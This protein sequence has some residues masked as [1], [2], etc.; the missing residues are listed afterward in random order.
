MNTPGVDVRN[1]KAVQGDICSN[2]YSLISKQTL[3]Q[4]E[5]TLW[6]ILNYGRVPNE[7]LNEITIMSILH[8]ISSQNL[9]NSEK[10]VK[11]GERENRIYSAL[12]RNKYIGFGHGIGRSGNLDDVQPKSAGNSV[13]AKATTSFVKDL[14]KSFGIKGCED[15]YILPYATGMCLSTCILYTKKEREKSEY[16]IVSRIDH[17][18]CYKCIDFCALKYLVVDMV[19]R[20]EELHTNLSEIEKL[21]QTY[22]EKICCVMSVTSSYAPRNSDDIV[23]IGHMCRRYNIPHIINNAFGLQCNY[24]C[25]EIQKCFE[26]KGRVD[27]VVQSCDK[28]F[29]VPVNGGIVF[30]SDKKKMK[31]LKKHYPGRTPVHAYLDLFITLL[32]LGK[33]KI[34]NLRKEREENFAW[35]KDKVSTLCSKYNLS[36]IKA[37]KNK[38][39][40]AINLNELYKIYHVENPRSI[41]L[42]GSLLF[43]R[44]VTGH[45]VICSPLLIR[46]GGVDPNGVDTTEQGEPKPNGVSF[47]NPRNNSEDAR[48]THSP[49]NSNQGG[50]KE[51][52]QTHL[53]KNENATH[54]AILGKGL[55][56]GNHTFEHFG[57]SYDLYPF[58]YIAFSCVIGIE[59]EELQSF[60]E[61]LDDAIG[62]FIRR[63][64]RRASPVERSY[65]PL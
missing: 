2:R 46:N 15:V 16:V 55:T 23:K 65:A 27:F 37:S 8:Q 64:G 21:I 18:T 36:L 22:G 3:N 40:M 45:R 7:G 5:N 54:A 50:V 62:C 43:Y 52:S 58:S 32:E 20:D 56:I 63:F 6:N 38:I 33:R 25:K 29:L 48:P 9:C 28:N 47:P 41:T 1:G 60:V 13:L 31:E 59:R 35:L 57:C 30:S 34:L 39:S 4:K 42:L 51:T 10:N 12:V 61:K 26:T 49:N 19:Y 11:I 24:L 14:I 44:N 53:V 17:K